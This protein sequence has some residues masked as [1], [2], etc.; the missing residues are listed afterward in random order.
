MSKRATLRCCAS[1]M[2]VFKRTP[3]TDETG[4]PQCGFGHYGARFALGPSCYRARITQ[5]PWF[6]RQMAKRADEL[7]RIVRDTARATNTIQPADGAA[8]ER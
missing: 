7:H 2:W 3:G 1:C 8:V 4:C 6:E 5:R